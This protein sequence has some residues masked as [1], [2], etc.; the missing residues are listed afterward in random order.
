MA[1]NGGTIAET[2]D[3]FIKAH[4]ELRSEHAPPLK[5]KQ[6]DYS[7]NGV[8]FASH[9]R[10]DLATI[11]KRLLI[12]D[13]TDST[14]HAIAKK[15]TTQQTLQHTR[16]W[17]KAQVLMY[18]LKCPDIFNETNLKS[19]F[20]EA[21]AKGLEGVPDEQK[22]V[23]ERQMKEYQLKDQKW[24]EDKAK[25]E[26]E[27]KTLK[28]QFATRYIAA[29]NEA[30]AHLD[31]DR[32]C[33]ELDP[34]TNFIV[35]RGVK[36]WYRIKTAAEKLGLFTEYA[37]SLRVERNIVVIG[38]NKKAVTDQV[39][40]V[41]LQAGDEKAADRKARFQPFEQQRQKLVQ[42]GDGG[43]V[44]GKWILDMPKYADEFFGTEECSMEI[45]SYRDGDQ[46]VWARLDL[47]V[48]QGWM[49]IHFDKTK[50][51]KKEWRGVEMKVDWEL[52]RESWGE[53]NGHV[54]EGPFEESE[55]S[56][57]FGSATECRGSLSGVIG[58]PYEF[59]GV[60][61]SQDSSV[62]AT[63]AERGYWRAEVEWEEIRSGWEEFE[64]EMNGY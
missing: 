51:G 31:P 47:H 15:D 21:L 61:I 37:G 17:W 5:Y 36:D 44:S 25:W 20:T 11:S 8:T 50:S 63:E 40:K 26:A 24:Q 19:I 38:N 35:L 12:D 54:G 46:F 18:G 14:S 43:N 58:G 13:S 52:E 9:H 23:E 39:N 3:K 34:S 33:R 49:K 27:L 10:A 4:P 59:V 45:A 62:S 7:F 16:F 32:F 2:V 29:T 56:I 1:D 41:K 6:L 28:D 30:K 22:E 60:K 55:G 42:T 57:T 53:P 64:Q 48:Y